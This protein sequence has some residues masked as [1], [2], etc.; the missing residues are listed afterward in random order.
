VSR[1]VDERLN[2]ERATTAAARLLQENYD[3]L[4]TWPLAITAYNHGANGMQR[5]VDAMGTTDID[6]IVQN[7]K[8]PAFGFASRNFYV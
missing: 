3:Y 8:G 7:Y 5:A 2:V 6:V 1:D 4:G